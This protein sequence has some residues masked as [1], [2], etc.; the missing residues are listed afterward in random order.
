[1]GHLGSGAPVKIA[2]DLAIN[3]F[4]YCGLVNLFNRDIAYRR[5]EVYN[6]HTVQR[7]ELN[8]PLINLSYVQHCNAMLAQFAES[9]LGKASGTEQPRLEMAQ[10]KIALTKGVTVWFLLDIALRNSYCITVYS[11]VAP[12]LRYPLGAFISWV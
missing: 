1:M 11:T 6:W 4:C 12:H 10:V 8:S 3:L 2:S 7:N 9:T 5:G